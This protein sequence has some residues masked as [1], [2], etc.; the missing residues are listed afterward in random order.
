MKYFC[1]GMRMWLR[2]TL[3]TSFMLGML[4]EIAVSKYWRLINI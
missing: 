1:N 4:Y 3:R 2:L